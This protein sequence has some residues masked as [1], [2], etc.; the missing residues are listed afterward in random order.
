MTYAFTQILLHP[1]SQEV[2]SF[3]TDNAVFTPTR[4]PKGS[5]DAAL[6]FIDVLKEFSECVHDAGRILS[7]LTSCLFKPVTKW[8]DRYF[9][10]KGIEYDPARVSV[11]Q[12]LPLPVTAAEFQQFLCAAGWLQD[13]IIDYSH[14]VQPLHALLGAVFKQARRTKRLTAD[15]NLG[16]TND[17]KA[18]FD[19][20]RHHNYCVFLMTQSLCSSGRSWGFLFTHVCDRNDSVPVLEQQHEV[21]FSKS[22]VFSDTE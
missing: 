18:A 20:A 8:C 7:V 11:L 12:T 4:V 5:T 15:F 22:G 13:L 2:M 9:N 19:T 6:E 17:A 1:D 21:L 16:W 3:V 14:I 10:G